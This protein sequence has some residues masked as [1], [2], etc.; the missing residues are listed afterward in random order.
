LNQ[1]RRWLFANGP[2]TNKYNTQRGQELINSN[3]LN[4]EKAKSELQTLRESLQRIIINTGISTREES[5][6]WLTVAKIFNDKFFELNIKTLVENTDYLQK[7]EKDHVLVCGVYTESAS[8]PL[9]MK[10][11]ESNKIIDKIVLKYLGGYIN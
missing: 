3:A 7:S 5:F 10:I 2:D 4:K 6:Y 11:I 8:S 1:E 9:L